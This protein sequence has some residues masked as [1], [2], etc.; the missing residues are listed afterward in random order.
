MV[1]RWHVYRPAHM[2]SGGTAGPRLRG[3]LTRAAI[4]AAA[5]HP[6]QWTDAHEQALIDGLTAEAAALGDARPRSTRSTRSAT[7]TRGAPAAARAATRCPPTI[8]DL[9]AA[10]GS[11]DLRRRRAAAGAIGGRVSKVDYKLSVAGWSVD[12]AADP[13]T[14]LV[15]LDVLRAMNSP[16]GHCRITAYVRPG[17]EPGGLEQLAGAAAGALGAWARPAAPRRPG[18]RRVRG[19]R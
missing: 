6:G 14:E 11:L 19:Q 4:P 10:R 2:V 5:G 17:G 15:E 3:A 8:G 9:S 16:A 1:L 18:E 13:R 7:G 12:S